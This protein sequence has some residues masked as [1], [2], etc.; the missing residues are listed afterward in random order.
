M[1]YNPW[2][3]LGLGGVKTSKDLPTHIGGW[4]LVE[5]E[6]MHKVRGSCHACRHAVLRGTP[7]LTVPQD[8][9]EDRKVLLDGKAVPAGTPKHASPAA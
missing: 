3:G 1:V 2:L 5:L 9:A 4:V 7:D 8:I 6:L